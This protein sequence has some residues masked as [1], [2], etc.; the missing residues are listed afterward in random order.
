MPVFFGSNLRM[1]IGVFIHFLT[2]NLLWQEGLTIVYALCIIGLLGIVW[3]RPLL[4]GALG[5][6]VFSLYFFRNPERVCAAAKADP[7]V[8][9]CPADGTVVDIQYAQ[10]SGLEGYAQKV[11]IFLSPFDVHVQWAPTAAQVEDVIYRPGAF[12]FAFL[13]KSSAL[14]EHNDLVL[15]S[16]Y[17]S[18]VV[19]QIAGTI[20]RRIVCWAHKGQ[21]LAVGQKYGMIRFGSRVDILLP[22]SVDLA[23]GI[24]QRVEG[25]HTVLGRWH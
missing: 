23:V 20:A 13:P 4:Y 7:K 22:E 18:L 19:R 25:G 6:L 1:E 9:V 2:N 5:F 17:G 24:G 8:L 11:S 12:T 15:H 14:N 21:Q 16:E 10:N 3:Y